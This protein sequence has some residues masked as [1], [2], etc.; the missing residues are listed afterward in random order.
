[1]KMNKEYIVRIYGRVADLA[2]RKETLSA[3]MI[4]LFV[5]GALF[6]MFIN[7]QLYR[8]GVHEGDVALKDVYSPYD[9]T[10]SWGI[11]EKKTEELKK[12]A[13]GNSPYIF[14]READVED[15][16]RVRLDK[17]FDMVKEEKAKSIPIGEKVLN[18]KNMVGEAFEDK[19]IKSILEHPDEKNL[20][21][22]S[23]EV[24]NN[25]FLTGYAKKEDIEA[26]K[27]HG[28]K[29]VAIIDDNTGA[30]MNRSLG[31]I[32]DGDSVKDAIETYSSRV[33]GS[34]RKT[35]QAVTGLL[36]GYVTPNIKADGSR[37]RATEESVLAG[38][39][40]VYRELEVKKNE[41]I[42]GRGQRVTAR[43]MVQL[44]HIR[45]IFKPGTTPKFFLGAVLLFGLLGVLSS[46]YFSFTEKKNFLKDTK[47]VAIVLLNML[48]A[49][50]FADIVMRSPQ[51]S[52]FIPLAGMGMVITL[53]VGFKSGFISVILMGLLI[54]LVAGGKVETMLVLLVGSAVGMYAV[55]D[56]RRRANILWAGLLVGLAKFVSIVCV[57]LI[58]NLD[59]DFFV[60]D[61]AWGIAS[62]I[63][64]AFLAMGLLPVFEYLFKV[65]TN[66]SLL[67]LSDLNHPLLKKLAIE[68]PGTY[69]HSIL[70]GNLAE[71]ACDAVGANSLLARVGAYYHDIGKI[72]KAEYF[73]ENEMTAG[74]RH[75]NLS[76]SMSALIISK[77]VKEG[78]DI[79]RKYKLNMNII[80]FITQHH[81][82]SLIAYFYQKALE[83]TK[84]EG[85]LKEDNFRYPGPRPQTKESAIILLA[86]S[87]EASSRAMEDPTPSSIRNLVKKIINNKFIDGQLEECD[88]T[89]KDMN[90]IADSFVR[91]LM[92]IYHTRLRY[93]EAEESDGAANGRP[94]NGDRNKK[95][96]QKKKDRPL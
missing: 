14:L 12:K 76:P 27:E 92:G 17:F 65:P 84:D 88:L 21:E 45:R 77:H 80:D 89:L 22:R 68:A 28:S 71:G 9:F 31:D 4:F 48:I 37:T 24:M 18:L 3:A 20:R 82:N 33:S 29:S 59:V 91:V 53:L 43:N 49:I 57:G 72:P 95:P 36:A 1:M 63:F 66:I 32:L 6:S 10:Y 47:N 73:S 86:D 16:A 55:K 94:A 56:C 85:S 90:K 74:S 93:P 61:G 7:P 41:I 52:Y 83:K 96:K 5:C 78:V 8:T 40:P 34:D 11:D 39:K 19:D 2:T 38:I 69:H 70:V 25:V 64:S 54:S 81:G 67:E 42:V 23:L 44:S 60:K 51:P 75:G 26:V 62:G 87:V 35:K 79:A 58:N 46:I 13:L 30:R 50:V 15:N